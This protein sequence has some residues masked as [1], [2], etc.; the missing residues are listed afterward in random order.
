MAVC[1]ERPPG[2]WIWMKLCRLSELNDIPVVQIFKNLGHGLTDLR[3]PKS[4]TA[5]L[6][7]ESEV[8]RKTA[9]AQPRLQVVTSTLT[10]TFSIL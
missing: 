7:L 2:G 5:N 8:V 3:G 1:T 9:L 6:S 10:V 4:L